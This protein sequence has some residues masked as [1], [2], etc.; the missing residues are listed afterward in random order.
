MKMNQFTEKLFATKTVS[1]WGIGYLG[2]TTILR[3]Q[4]KGFFVNCSTFEKDVQN[5]LQ[6]GQYPY[7]D[8]KQTW[9]LNNDIPKIDLSKI[10]FS[11]DH[12]D[13][14]NSNVHIIAL[15]GFKNDS[16]KAETYN[17]LIDIFSK[18]IDKL[19]G[20]LILFQSAEKVGTVKTYFVNPLKKAGAK[21]Y[22]ASGFR[23]DWSIEEF[24]LGNETR[25]IAADDK[26]SLEIASHFFNIMEISFETLDSIEEAEIY[27]NGKN[28][29]KY[30]VEAFFTQLSFAYPDINI[31]D[32]SAM[33]ANNFEFSSKRSG[34]NLLNHK[35]M[36]HIDHLL[37]GEYGD[38]LSIV[39][40]TQAINLNAVLLYA[41]LLKHNKISSVSIMGISVEGARKDIRASAAILLAEYLHNIGLDVFVHD[42]YF[43][44]NEIQ[45][46]LPFAK[47]STFDD[48]STKTE[49]YVIMSSNL[50]YKYLTQH[51]IQQYGLYDAKI[52][53]DNIGVFKNFSFSPQTKYHEV[54]DGGLKALIK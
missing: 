46:L 44:N 25:I 34:L 37:G 39:K 49:S 24:L 8:M 40:E 27:E 29:L 21:C 18:N 14:F 2:Y 52:I 48:H 6:T 17:K 51:N 13:M 1:V 15:P 5:D 30:S 45:T 26:R 12:T 38:H 36:L 32:V 50:T 19:N 33:I 16:G 4:S 47:I 28:C 53:I 41:D 43:T 10:V 9:S 11:N 23:S 20:S 42:P 3:L 7:E 31:N 54:G 22:F 35:N